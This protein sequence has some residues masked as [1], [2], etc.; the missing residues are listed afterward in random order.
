MSMALAFALM[1]WGSYL[2]VQFAKHQHWFNFRRIHVVMQA[3]HLTGD[4]VTQIVTSHLQG[5][6]FSLNVA[7]L[8]RALLA[9]PWVADVAFRRVWPDMLEVDVAAFRCHSRHT[10]RGLRKRHDTDRN[11]QMGQRPRSCARQTAMPADRGSRPSADNS[12]ARSRQA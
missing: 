4:Q 1:A 10:Y 11:S 12:T 8:R 7:E 3:Q 2:L 6:F 9:E 5:G